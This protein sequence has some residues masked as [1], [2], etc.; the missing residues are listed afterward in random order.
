[1]PEEKRTKK[2]KHLKNTNLKKG[3]NVTR[4]QKIISVE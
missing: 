2:N 4:P 1:M 3:F